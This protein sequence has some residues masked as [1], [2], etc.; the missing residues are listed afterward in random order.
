MPLVN[1]VSKIL[2]PITSFLI[3]MNL[4]S[5]IIVTL[6][7]QLS[8]IF[9]S[10]FW[11]R[12]TCGFSYFHMKHMKGSDRKPYCLKEISTCLKEMYWVMWSVEGLASNSSWLLVLP[13]F[14]LSICVVLCP[15][16][17]LG[18]LRPHI[19]IILPEERGSVSSRSSHG[20]QQASFFQKPQET[21]LFKTMC[22]MPTLNLKLWS[23]DRMCGPP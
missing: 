15:F 14:I 2:A 22:Y 16:T 6:G 7:L 10:N 20:K 23:W 12:R 8:W 3:Y 21:S 17:A 13:P 11:D 1:F 18:S 4:Y 19:L 5:R 9:F